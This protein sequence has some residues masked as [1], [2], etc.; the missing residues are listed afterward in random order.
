MDVIFFFFFSSRRRHTRLQGD[1]S[2]DVCSSD[3]EKRR[4]A[5]AGELGHREG[6]ASKLRAAQL[7]LASER[8]S[9]R[10]QRLGLDLARKIRGDREAVRSDDE[11]AGDVLELQKL[12]EQAAE[13][14]S[15][16]GTLEDGGGHASSD[17]QLPHTRSRWATAV[18]A[19]TSLSNARVRSAA[20]SV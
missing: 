17:R 19:L 20:S 3:L 11:P 1:W 9:E 2:S 10:G 6:P 14:A 13:V 18:A 16:R 8:R 15:E 7:E 12:R 4:A 5:H